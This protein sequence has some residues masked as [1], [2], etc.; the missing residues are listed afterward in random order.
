MF[1]FL[2]RMAPSSY[3][4]RAMTRLRAVG[5]RLK[6]TTP[7]EAKGVPKKYSGP[8]I[9]FS[10]TGGATKMN[11]PQKEGAFN[12]LRNPSGGLRGAFAVAVLATGAAVFY[13][14]APNTI[15]MGSMRRFTQNYT[16]G[17]VS[18]TSDEMMEIVVEAATDLG[19]SQKELDSIKMYVCTL[20]ECISFGSYES[21]R[22][23]A[24]V[25][26]PSY[27]HFQTENDVDLTEL[28]LGMM[29]DGKEQPGRLAEDLKKGREAGAFKKSLVLTRDEKKFAVAREIAR[30]GEE[31]FRKQGAILVTWI[32]FNFAVIGAMRRFFVMPPLLRKIVS[33]GSVTTTAPA[34][35]VLQDTIAVGHDLKAD[36]RVCQVSPEMAVAGKSYYDKMLRRH[37]ALRTLTPENQGKKNFNLKGDHF[38]GLIRSYPTSIAERRDTCQSMMT[39]GSVLHTRSLNE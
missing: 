34:C 24:A 12:S 25:G 7:P 31:A 28:R 19:L 23:G 10:P 13:R 9:K 11:E 33:I 21:E 6:S 17:F 18:K 15:L 20:S 39:S 30:S 4:S 27:F 29:S 3:S 36:R 26:Y 37:L 38:P 22:F 8:S 35:V 16:T 2:T 1:L 32:F 5:F 14:V